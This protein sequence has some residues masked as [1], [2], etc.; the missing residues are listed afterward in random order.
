MGFRQKVQIKNVMRR[1]HI[2]CFLQ[3]LSQGRSIFKKEIDKDFLDIFFTIKIRER[4][5]SPPFH[6]NSVKKIL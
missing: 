3:L 2:F 5:E 1:W 6:Q 4:G